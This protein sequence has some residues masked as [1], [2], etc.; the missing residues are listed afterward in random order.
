M[1]LTTMCQLISSQ[2]RPEIW[3]RPIFI[4]KEM[5]RMRRDPAWHVAQDLDTNSNGCFLEQ[6]NGHQKCV[7]QHKER[8]LTDFLQK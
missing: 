1:S 5:L 7:D 8:Y 6:S 3:T 2:L 4:D